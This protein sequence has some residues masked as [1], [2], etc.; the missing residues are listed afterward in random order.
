MGELLAAFD[1]FKDVEPVNAIKRSL[2]QLPE[3]DALDNRCSVVISAGG[4]S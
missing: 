2:A 1:V 4:P 3:G